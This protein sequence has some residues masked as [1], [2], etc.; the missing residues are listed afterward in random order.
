MNQDNFGETLLTAKLDP[1]T[2]RNWQR[3]SQEHKEVPPFT[4]LLDFIDLQVR[5]TESKVCDVVK[6]HPTA[7]YPDKNTIKSYTASVEDTC[8]A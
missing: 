5:D 2:L 3:S 4:D 6:K 8:V 7:S 1:T